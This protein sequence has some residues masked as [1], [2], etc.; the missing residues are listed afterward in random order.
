MR[1]VFLNTFLALFDDVGAA[2]WDSALTSKSASWDEYWN[3][4]L[5]SLGCLGADGSALPKD[6]RC[7]KCGCMRTNTCCGR[8]IRGK[9]GAAAR[10]L[11]AHSELMAATE[12]A[13]RNLAAPFTPACDAHLPSKN[14]HA[15]WKPVATNIFAHVQRTLAVAIRRLARHVASAVPA[16][17]AA[18]ASP[19]PT[20]DALEAWEAASYKAA[21]YLLL[22]IAVLRRGVD[23]PYAL[24]P[25]TSAELHRYGA[26]TLATLARIVKRLLPTDA[27]LVGDVAEY[28]AAAIAARVRGGALRSRSSTLGSD[29]R[30]NNA[31]CVFTVTRQATVAEA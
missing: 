8:G 9:P 27:A 23:K 1:M 29:M 21:R 17:L 12:T 15:R 28:G 22:L 3:W 6:A 10:L 19:A 25:G 31:G 11:A 20:R 24:V 7:T 5:Y 2:G 18:A 30:T 16:A 26:V 4:L 14:S 13:T